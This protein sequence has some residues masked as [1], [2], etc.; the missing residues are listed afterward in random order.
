MR[1]KPQIQITIGKK[2]LDWIDEKRRTGVYGS[3]SH[4]IRKAVDLLIW[5]MSFNP[6][7][8]VAMSLNIFLAPVD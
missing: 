7:L 2:Q 8:C 5:V 1:R 4:A 3:R 6:V